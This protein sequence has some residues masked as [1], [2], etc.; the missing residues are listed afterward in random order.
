[1]ELRN[2]NR[3]LGKRSLKNEVGFVFD[4]A[5]KPEPFC[6]RCLGMAEMLK[7]APMEGPSGNKFIREEEIMLDPPRD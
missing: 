1:L 4:H 7:G 5:T 2:G 6:R 3:I